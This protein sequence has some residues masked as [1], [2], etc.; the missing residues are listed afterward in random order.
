LNEE[1]QTDCVVI[2]FIL[3]LLLLPLSSSCPERTVYYFT[4]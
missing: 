1:A 4:P 2:Q 3:T